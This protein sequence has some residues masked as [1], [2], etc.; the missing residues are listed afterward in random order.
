MSS[1]G[2]GA[3]FHVTLKANENAVAVADFYEKALKDK[4]LAVQ[5]SEHKMNADMMTTLVGKKDKTEATVT[6]MQK[7][8][9]AT[10]V[11]VNWV[12]K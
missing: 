2:K 3:Q 5:R 10:T 9:E 12:S 4:G 7:S 8:G 6:A 1:Q 11:M